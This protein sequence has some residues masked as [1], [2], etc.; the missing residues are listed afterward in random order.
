MSR[1]PTRVLVVA[2]SLAR[3][4]GRGA[5]GHRF[6]SVGSAGQPSSPTVPSDEEMS[7]T[8]YQGQIGGYCTVTSS[9]V[10]AITVGTKISMPRPLVRTRWTVTSSSTPGPATPRRVIAHSILRPAS[11]I[12]RSPVGPGRSTASMLA[13]MSRISAGTTGPGTGRTDSRTDGDEGDRGGRERPA[14]GS[15]SLAARLAFVSLSGPQRAGRNLPFRLA[16]SRAD[17]VSPL[18]R[19]DAAARHRHNH[20]SRPLMTLARLGH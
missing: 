12:A 16:R 17:G 20:Q 15:P 1:A 13:S 6:R 4:S 19:F 2:A 7:P 10:A 14:P 5:R 18:S 3:G 8:Q 9:N 11:G